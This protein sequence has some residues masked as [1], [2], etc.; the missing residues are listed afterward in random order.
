[1][2]ITK[3]GHLRHWAY[4]STAQKLT[5]SVE[6]DGFSFAFIL[7]IAFFDAYDPEIWNTFRPMSKLIMLEIFCL[8][9][10]GMRTR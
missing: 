9:D 8:Q 7:P 10:S 2:Q 1:M 3:I 6:N 5:W 4:Y